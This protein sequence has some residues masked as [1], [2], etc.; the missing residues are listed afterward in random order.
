M[1]VGSFS[2]KGLY[3][4]LQG[5]ASAGHSASVVVSVWLKSP[6]LA[7]LEKKDIANI[8]TIQDLMECEVML[9]LGDFLLV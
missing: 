6:K 8:A 5:N 3:L 2:A 4:A 7:C 1:C 9:I